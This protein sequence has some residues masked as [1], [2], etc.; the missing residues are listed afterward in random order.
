MFSGFLVAGYEVA[1]LIHEVAT[2]SSCH[3][4]TQG[5]QLKVSLQTV[6]L[7]ILCSD[8]ESDRSNWSRSF[9]EAPTAA[10]L[11][12][13]PLYLGVRIGLKKLSQASHIYLLTNSGERRQ[14]YFFSPVTNFGNFFFHLTFHSFSKH[15]VPVYARHCNKNDELKMNWIWSLPGRR[16]SSQSHEQLNYTLWE[17]KRRK[18]AW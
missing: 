1:A 11:I 9:S 2:Y 14:F 17:P 16:C 13:S 3:S 18:T 15:Q 5:L 4:V 6:C 12:A 8:L 10:M 7:Q